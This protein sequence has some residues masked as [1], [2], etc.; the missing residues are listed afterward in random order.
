MRGHS[1]PG[2]MKCKFMAHSGR[3]NEVEPGLSIDYV[4][5]TRR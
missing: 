4:G 3:V 5:R 1:G 2:F